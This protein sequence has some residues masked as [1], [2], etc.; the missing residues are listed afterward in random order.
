MDPK[1]PPRRSAVDELREGMLE[2]NRIQEEERQRVKASFPSRSP[3]SLYTPSE[4]TLRIR[5][6]SRRSAVDILREGM[7]E[8]MDTAFPPTAPS[9]ESAAATTVTPSDPMASTEAVN[10]VNDTHLPTTVAP[11]DL[12]MSTADILG[13]VVDETHLA[14]T[15]APS[16]LTASV[17][18]LGPSDEEHLPATVAPSDLTTTSADFLGGA[19]YDNVPQEIAQEDQLAEDEELVDS[20]QFGRRSHPRYHQEMIVTLPMAANTRKIYLDTIHQ[21]K[22]TIM[23]FGKV[24]SNPGSHVPSVAVESRLDEFF[25]RLYDLC[26]LPAYHDD[27]HELDTQ[28][29]MKHATNS[30]SK[31]S[32]VHELL[33]GVQGHDVRILI[34]S[35]PGK[36]FDYLQAVVSATDPNFSV[37]GRDPS[38]SSP[39]STIVL[40]DAHQDFT[41]IQEPFEA[42]ILFDHVARPV[43][44]P[45]ALSHDSTV[46]LFLV[47]TFSLEHVEMEL[48]VREP[49]L[50]R[51][52]RKNALNLCTASAKK[53]LESMRGGHHEP[54]E[55]ADLFSNFLKNADEGFNWDPQAVPEEVFEMWESSQQT[56]PGEHSQSEMHQDGISSK[57]PTR[58]RRQSDE[59]SGS[60]KRQR[61]QYKPSVPMTDLLKDTLAR[62]PVEGK[63]AEAHLVQVPLEQLEA[64]AAKIFSLEDRI[65]TDAGSNSGYRDLSVS[66]ESQLES[67]K[68][69]VTSLEPKFHEALNDRAQFEK[70]CKVAVKTASAA[71]TNLETS[72]AEVAALKDQKMAL[73]AKL[74]EAQAALIHSE[75]PE[76]AKL[77]QLEKEL[78]EERSA[79][80]KLKSKLANTEQQLDYIRKA[81]QDQSNHQMDLDRTI[82]DLEKENADLKHKASSNLLELHEIHARNESEFLS[83]QIDERT[84]MLQDREREL[85]R[86]REELRGLKSGRRETRQGSVPRSPRPGLMSPRPGRGGISGAGS[87][88]TSPAAPSSSVGG[89]SYMTPAGAP[90]RWAG[91]LQE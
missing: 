48:E 23:D 91:H 21:S 56:R 75:I 4:S 28:E 62:F 68:R 72:K 59:E 6:A 10:G 80:L 41:S 8:F 13:G 55:A 63:A 33:N 83:K 89:L 5:A 40:A 7:Q 57:L 25:Q 34:V 64:L 60:I 42:V 35:R 53:A 38:A 58:K 82:K 32:F 78:E 74:A 11:S 19:H 24:F 49:D 54:H 73:E 39:E 22:T 30:N 47:A 65:A 43:D 69:T 37:L 26:D 85:D 81:Y 88:G 84:A 17:D 15:V 50:N 29:M 90:N 87:R 31:F 12:T 79:V 46:F 51:L 2:L 86:A 14:T 61:T 16:D 77:G 70:E 66:L 1:R 9:R 71:T 3:N 52:E 67:W 44:L 76:V 27:L 36:V 18:M 45:L 20:D